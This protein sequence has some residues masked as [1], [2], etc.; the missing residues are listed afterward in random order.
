MSAIGKESQTTHRL[1]ASLPHWCVLRW[2]HAIVC[3]AFSIAFLYFSYLPIPVGA[4][5]QAVW[6]GNL[7]VQDGLFSGVLESD[8]SLPLSEGM[9]YLHLSWLSSVITW[10]AYQVDGANGIS[11]LFAAI[12][13]STLMLR[14]RLFF[15]LSNRWW[16][17][18]GAIFLAVACVFHF[19]G[20]GPSCFGWFCFAL[21]ANLVFAA[22]ENQT[23]SSADCVSISTGAWWRWLALFITMVIWANLDCSFLVGLVW[24]AGLT[25][26]RLADSVR[27]FALFRSD[28]EL[29][30]RLWLL[31]LLVLAS[32][33]TPLSWTAWQAIFCSQG[34]PIANSL[35][36]WQPVSL[37]SWSGAVIAV[38]WGIWFCI[39]RN[40]RTIGIANLVCPV[41]ATIAVA[42][43]A[44]MLIWFAPLMLIAA[45]SMATPAESDARPTNENSEERP[46]RFAFTLICGLLIW[47]GFS[48]SPVSQPV[49]GGTKRTDAQLH[50]QG[51]PFELKS[52][53]ANSWSDK[54]QKQH[55]PTPLLWSPNYW[56]DFIQ[57][58]GHPISVFANSNLTSL[59]DLA[60][61]DYHAIYAGRGSW[62]KTL[63]RYAVTDLV[64]DKKHQP[65]LYKNVHTSPGHWRVVYEDEQAMMLTRRKSNVK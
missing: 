11:I 38:A 9:Q 17:V 7:I 23:S 53:I 36:G 25:I 2:H 33:L 4:T 20:L 31:E 6:Q 35:G 14:A 39:A 45:C 40:V 64:V 56:S 19:D 1:E 13:T 5:W 54:K 34:N 41:I 60:Q 52:F 24:I 49:L 8:A 50:S 15:K 44:P 18:F 29:R 26:G 12:Q 3:C 62:A 30:A 57:P 21:F 37:A 65:I 47:I 58:P 55:H 27:G 10:L 48:L 28:T 32:L 59:P 43:S 16:S 63:E 51:T 42:I 46:L 22:Q 61:T